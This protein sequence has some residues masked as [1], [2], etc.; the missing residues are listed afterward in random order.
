LKSDEILDKNSIRGNGNTRKMPAAL[1]GASSR[2]P[3]AQNED[4]A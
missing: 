2:S 1:L 4:K 3:K